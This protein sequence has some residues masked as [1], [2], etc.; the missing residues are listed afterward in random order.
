[1]VTKLGE[2]IKLIVLVLAFNFS[3]LKITFIAIIEDAKFILR[4]KTRS[5]YYDYCIDW[6]QRGQNLPRAL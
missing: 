5:D 1:M 2:N 6:S 3:L 4:I